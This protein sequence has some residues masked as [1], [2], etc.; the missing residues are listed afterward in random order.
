MSEIMDYRGFLSAQG[1]KALIGNGNI[2][3]KDDRFI[4]TDDCKYRNWTPLNGTVITRRVLILPN[5]LTNK[6]FWT[7]GIVFA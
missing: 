2:K 3:D 6:K 5:L 1:P 7:I 4:F